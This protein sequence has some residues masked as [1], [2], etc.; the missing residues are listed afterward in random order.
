MKHT[1]YLDLMDESLFI[2]GLSPENFL[3]FSSPEAANLLVST[4]NP[5]LC[6]RPDVSSTR[7]SVLALYSQPIRFDGKSESR[8]LPVLQRGQRSQFFVLT[9]SIAASAD[10]NG[11]LGF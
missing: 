9:E 4:K 2:A 3:A 5:N 8:R 7:R 11:F 6:V 1:K 10:E